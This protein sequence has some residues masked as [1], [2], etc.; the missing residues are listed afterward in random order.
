MTK[1]FSTN[2]KDLFLW[3]LDEN[4]KY[5]VVQWQTMK[6]FLISNTTDYFITIRYIEF[7]AQKVI[8]EVEINGTA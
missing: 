1:E 4:T 2:D 5:S 7:L 6:T 8:K 3:F